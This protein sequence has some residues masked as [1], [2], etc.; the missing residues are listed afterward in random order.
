MIEYIF[1][2]GIIHIVFGFLWKWVFVLPVVALFT[3]I[4]FNKGIYLVKTFGY[5]L[6][7][8]LIAILTLSTIEGKSGIGSLII[9]PLIGVF[10]IYMATASGVHEAEKQASMEYDYETLS[11]LRYDGLFILGAVILFIVTLFVPAIAVNLLTQWLFGVIDWGYN[12]PV[13]GWIVRILG[14]LFLLNIFWYGFI[15]S[16][17]LIG[18]VASKIKGESGNDYDEEESIPQVNIQEEKHDIQTTESQEEHKHNV[19]EIYRKEWAT[20]TPEKRV[21]LNKRMLRWQ[22]LMKNGWTP[23]QAYYEVTEEEGSKAMKQ[24]IQPA[25]K[26]CPF[27]A[28]EIASEAVKCR[29][30]GEWLDGRKARLTPSESALQ[31][32]SNAQ[33]VWHFV[34][35]SLFT[36]S[37]YHIYWFYRNWKQLRL[38]EGWDISPG[39]RT[40]GIFV[41]ILN[42]F[43]IYNQF[44]HIRDFARVAECDRLFSVGWITLGWI[45]FNALASLPDPFWFLS[46]LSIWPLGVVQGVLNSYWEKQQPELVVR[47]KLSGGQIALLVIGG[48]FWIIVLI[49]T[50]MPD[51]F[52]ETP[53]PLM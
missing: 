53:L 11:L 31:R 9:Y 28:E 44:R 26:K 42:I 43:L 8:S 23:S 30:C 7:V 41:P 51:P 27:C 16:L 3:L 40:V 25:T 1:Y 18:F 36:F 15:M 39:W 33:P 49:G 14:A 34:L 12:L 6:L 19:W 48:I 35:L 2:L 47:T 45:F 50:F 5:Y 20:A 17:M 52:L 21:E 32:F 38:Q 24:E 46:F 22:E 29:Y 10:T 37:L 4:K 13:I